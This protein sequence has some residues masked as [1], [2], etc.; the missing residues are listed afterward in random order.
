MDRHSG[1]WFRDFDAALTIL[2]ANT[3]PVE[4]AGEARGSCTWKTSESS[5][6]RCGPVHCLRSSQFQAVAHTVAALTRTTDPQR[7]DRRWRQPPSALR[8]LF[9]NPIAIER[10]RGHQPRQFSHNRLEQRRPAP[11]RRRIWP[12]DFQRGPRQVLREGLEHRHAATDRR[13]DQPR[14]RGQRRQEFI[15]GRHVP[16]TDRCGD[17][18]MVHRERLR[19]LDP[20]N[21]PAF[22]NA[23][24]H[25]ARIRGQTRPPGM[26]PRPVARGRWERP[27]DP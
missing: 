26:T 7:P 16:G 2:R 15:L 18:P 11:D 27:A 3:G 20:W 1:R 12:E 13:T 22:P 10:N 14:R 25:P 24:S 23:A 8:H 21:A 6:H 9:S 19:L 4:R 17:R 5:P